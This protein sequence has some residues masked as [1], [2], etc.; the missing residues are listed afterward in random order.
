MNEIVRNV[1]RP[2]RRYDGVLKVTG[3]AKYAAE[4]SGAGMLYGYV[5]SSRIAK[6]RITSLDTGPAK[7]VP[8]VFEVFTHENSPKVS[9]KTEDYQD[10]VA[11]PG[12]PLR[13]LA[14]DKVRF[15]GQPVAL[16]LA[17]TFETARYAA[18]LV[19]VTYEESAPVT[20]LVAAEADAYDP[21]EKR[22]GIPPPPDPRGDSRGAFERAQVKV[23]ATY[24]TAIEHH[25]PIELHATTAFPLDDGGVKVH[26]KTQGVKNTQ[27]YL[28][29]VFGLSKEK[30]EVLSPFMG[31]GFGCGL[32][33]IYQVFL[34]VMAALELRRPV[35]VVLTRAQMFSFGY[36]PGSLQTVALGADRHGKLQAVIQDA[37]AMTSTYED[38][39][40]PFVNF[41]GMLYDCA[42]VA[43]S[44]RLAKLDLAT[45]QDMRAPG[46]VLGVYALETA[47]DELAYA[48]NFDPL[49]LRLTNYSHSDG[50]EGKSFTSKELRACYLEAA[51]AFGWADRS[52]APRSMRDGTSLVGWG[53]ATGVWEAFG[54]PTGARASLT[55]D[56]KLTIG[57]ATSDLGTGTYTILQQ[58]ASDA[59]GISLDDVTVMLGDSSLPEAPPAGGSWTAASSGSAVLLA[60]GMLKEKL[61]GFARSMDQ[62]PLANHGIEHV[63]FAGGR[64]VSKADP[65]QHV[66]LSDAVKAAGTD[67]LEEVGMFKPDAESAKKY[68]R[69][70]H[71][72]VF[73][74]VKVDEDLGTV[75]LTRIVSA[76]A[77]GKILNPRTARS[78]IVGGITFGIG[79]ALE[80]ETMIDHKLGRIMNRNLGEY[81][82]P[83]Q[84]DI[85]D[86]E[87]IFVEEEDRLINPLGVKGLGE[88]GT[89]GTA[90]AIGNAI[91][92]ATG[93][94]VRD[95]PITIDKLIDG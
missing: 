67:R 46:A 13:P 12:H 63:D 44:Y 71:S 34:A 29:K 86:I 56:G 89:V 7:S 48:G 87:V 81:H 80:E 57:N 74:E 14:E 79:M 88:I 91:F 38:Y 43:V 60:C 54:M 9:G 27:D 47:M 40:E 59:L 32:R 50:N 76:I 77:A 25:N 16:V 78:Q 42:N 15:A 72:A 52:P 26:E 94:R 33:P 58:I 28:T 20:D 31:G 62:S 24:G 2:V 45:P 11:P 93:K 70:T 17:D 49:E 18:S 51:K 21:P 41:S 90:A 3:G 35:K 37:V 95:L 36:R 69:Y 39:Q 4:F 83:V 6:G 19:T 82:V 68:S 75:R 65:S 5:V 84:A 66:T 64:I 8:G 55:A 61:L 1:G 53:M 92:H 73:A 10:A 23:R 85:Q 30:V 22:E